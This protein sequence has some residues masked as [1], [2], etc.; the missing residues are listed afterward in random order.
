MEATQRVETTR[1]RLV[2]VWAERS[3]ASIRL[4]NYLEAID[5]AARALSFSPNN[6]QARAIEREVVV[7]IEERAGKVLESAD[8]AQALR[9]YDAV[10]ERLGNQGQEAQERRAEIRI[11]WS[12]DL[13]KRADV[14]EQDSQPARGVLLLSKAFALTADPELASR[15]D[16]YLDR[17]RAERRYKVLAVG[18]SAE[19][20]FAYV[21]ERLMREMMGPF[22]E[23]Y[24]PTVD[25]PQASL[26]LAVGKPRFDTDRRTRTERVNYQSGTRQA[27][28]PHYKSRQDRVHDEER[29]VLEVEQEITRQQQYVSKY[30]SDVEREGPSP[31]VSTG[32]EQNL[33]NARSRLE[34]AQRRVIDQRQQLQRARDDLNNSPQFVEEAVYSDH[35]YTVTTH[36]LRAAASL[37]GELTHRDGRAAIPLDAQLQ[38]E[39]SDDEYAAQPVINLAE[40]R[41]ELPSAQALTP[42]LYEQAYRRSYDALAH[43]FEQHRLELFDRAKNTTASDQRSELYVIYMLM[44][45]GSIEPS[46][47]IALA[48]LEG[49]PDSVAVLTQLAR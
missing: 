48:A 20:G 15:R 1:V 28:N 6:P 47:S 12:K 9:L 27:P 14:A 29:R 17:V 31:N 11:R 13:V 10:F 34:S 19:A 44:D 42:R 33:S 3:R 2:E 23:V 32:A 18:N 35:T 49:I 46:A 26:R 38:V 39:A 43:S 30:Q 25:K 24:S 41:L 22:F 37:H 5:N 21:S 40:R 36:T 8:F 4:E 45:L 7:R 16:A